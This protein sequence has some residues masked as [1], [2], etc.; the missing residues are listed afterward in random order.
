MTEAE[1]RAFLRQPVRTAKLAT[2]R[3]DGRPHVAPIWYDLDGD[4]IV[5]TTGADSVKGQALRRD[6]RV[7]LCVDDDQ[8]PFAFVIVEGIATISEDP[9]ELLAWATRIGGRYMGAANADAYGARNGAPGE[10]LVR[11]RPTH[12]V[13]LSRVAD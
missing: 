6:P 4:E 9:A 5:F 1:W 13:A 10:L 7:S 2:V 3:K 12:V 8:P 11:V